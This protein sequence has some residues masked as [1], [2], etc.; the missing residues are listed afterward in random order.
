MKIVTLM[1]GLLRML[2]D[3]AFGALV[4]HRCDLCREPTIMRIKDDQGEITWCLVCAA[5]ER[6]RWGL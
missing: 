5:S 1:G 6:R 2:M 3:R 4:G